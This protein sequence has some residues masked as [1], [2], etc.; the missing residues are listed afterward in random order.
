MISDQLLNQVTIWPRTYD[1]RVER[2]R[3]GALCEDK[4]PLPCF[5]HRIKM[6][7]SRLAVNFSV[8]VV[9]FFRYIWSQE[10]YND[11]WSVWCEIL[12]LLKCKSWLPRWLWRQTSF[13]MT[14]SCYIP[15]MS[16]KLETN[17]CKQIF[18][19][20]PIVA[21]NRI[22]NLRDLLVRST[23]RGF[24]IQQERPF[25]VA[26]QNAIVQ[27]RSIH[28]LWLVGDCVIC[29]YN[30]PARGDYIDLRLL[31]MRSRANTV[32]DTE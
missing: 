25:P 8:A 16:V 17:C 20:P 22:P 13:I 12:S 5:L 7:Y 18:P 15:P 11:K 27:A 30:H 24:C 32:R 31:W 28:A 10:I 9:L 14:A 26:F 6:L 21:Y 23:L 2:E 1:W 4:T 19:S 29:R 3:G